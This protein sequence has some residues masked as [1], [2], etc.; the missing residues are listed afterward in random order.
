MRVEFVGRVS[1]ISQPTAGKNGKSYISARVTDKEG[2]YNAIS[3]EAGV[4]H[5]EDGKLYSFEAIARAFIVRREYEAPRAFPSFQI[6]EAVE[7]FSDSELE[8]RQLAAAP[9]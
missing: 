1:D 7:L 5:L 2:Y 3:Y 8:S 4:H 9:F 6:L